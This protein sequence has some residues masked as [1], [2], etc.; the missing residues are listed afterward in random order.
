M[1][2][3]G[4]SVSGMDLMLQEHIVNRPEHWPLCRTVPDA[5]LC[6]CRWRVASFLGWA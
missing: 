3:E 1:L 2:E 5:W 6:C 4:G